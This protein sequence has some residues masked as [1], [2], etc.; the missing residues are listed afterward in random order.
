MR[1]RMGFDEFKDAVV[2]EIK[3]WLPEQFENAHVSLQAVM[4][5]NDLRLTGLTIQR[6]GSSVAPTIYLESFYEWYQQGAELSEI[7]RK[8][9]EVRVQNEMEGGFD[10]S[11]ITDFEKC[12]DKIFPRLI[13]AE[14]NRELLESSP[15]IL[16]EDLA[17]TFHIDL[18]VR[19]D[20]AMSV[21]IHNDLMN[22]WNVTT[23]DL[24]ELA[25]GNLTDSD[26][27]L[28]ESMNEMMAEMLLPNLI[29]VCNGDRETAEQM[30]ESMMIPEN[31]MFVLSKKDKVHGACEI[32]N[33][34]LMQKVVDRIGTGFYILPS[35]I[36]E[37][38]VIPADADLD[39]A[40]L[41]AM[42]REVN[43][44]TVDI[45]ERLSDNVYRYSPEEGLKIA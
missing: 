34:N 41:V 33:E 36:H 43:R 37:L 22:S 45:E 11:Q 14:W 38:L 8:I 3:E 21:P 19:N 10:V 30:L 15:H 32:L 29:D 24:Y 13:G 42:V 12:R 25:V 5:N 40:E 16:M 18:G 44:S 35:S 28:F 26:A 7:L 1:E 4:K 17:V 31:A 9:A 20:G 27:G 6:M 23:E 39:P 2:E